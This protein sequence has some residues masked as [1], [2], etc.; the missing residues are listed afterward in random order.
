ML[1]ALEG[2]N[3]F[4]DKSHVLKDV[5]LEVDKGEVVALLGRNGSGRSTTL[6][7][8]MGV[9]P[10]R[11]GTIRLG[12]TPIE[13]KNPFTLARRGIAFVPE[14]RRIFPNLTVAENLRLAALA[15]RK[16]PWTE[17][18]VFDYF[19]VLGERRNSLAR[20]SGGEQQMLAIA[21]ALIANP[22]IIL[23][24]EPMEGLAPMIAR[25][26]EEVVRNI[27]NEGNTILLVEQNAEVAMSLAD[28]GY[29]LSNGRV[30]ASGPIG[31]LRADPE[32]MQR[33]LAV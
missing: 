12:G 7:T 22:D 5:S 14:D 15:G 1:L 2:V 8:I 9:V 33:Y 3:T 13:R 28:R 31:E 27:K 29:I 6:K 30:M 23:L 10:P 11:S 26:V 17:K 16:G 20:L 24:D 4:Y 19:A 32:L 25:N 18:R 21:R